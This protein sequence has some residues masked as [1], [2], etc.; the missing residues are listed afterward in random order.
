MPLQTGPAGRWKKMFPEHASLLIA[1]LICG[2]ST[3]CASAVGGNQPGGSSKAQ[4]SASASSTL[5]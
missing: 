4:A 3:A 2:L 5:R 1:V